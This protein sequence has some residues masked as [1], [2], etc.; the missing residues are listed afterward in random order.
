[1][2]ETSNG[3][4]HHGED[5]YAQKLRLYD[6][7]RVLPNNVSRANG[8]VIWIAAIHIP[9][10]ATFAVARAQWF[11]YLTLFAS[12]G[13]CCALAVWREKH[14]KPKQKEFTGTSPP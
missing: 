3:R 13:L 10:F 5:R 14:A 8:A 1:M 7:L 4:G 12:L 2:A 9:V 6:G 11:A